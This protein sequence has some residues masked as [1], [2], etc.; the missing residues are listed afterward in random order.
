MSMLETSI[1]DISNNVDISNNLSEKELY[2][3]KKKDFLEKKKQQQLN[4]IIDVIKRQTTYDDE[5]I[6]EKLKEFDNDPTKVIKNYLGID[7]NK[8]KEEK[9]FSSINQGIY[10]EIR[11]LMDD[12]STQHRKRQEMAEYI[13][14][15]NELRQQQQHQQHQQHQQ[16][17]NKIIENTI[18]EETNEDINE[19]EE[20][21][22]QDNTDKKE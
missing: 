5:T 3:I 2:E 13:N 22:K 21:Q 17:Q 6:K 14:K 15:V 12:A 20:T 18:I 19:N 9:K 10:T 8:K 7:V 11:T 1:S 16:Q 4:H